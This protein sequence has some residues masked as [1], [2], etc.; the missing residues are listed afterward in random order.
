VTSLEVDVDLRDETGLADELLPLVRRYAE[1]AIGAEG[2][3]GSYELAVTLVDDERIRELNH[4]HRDKNEVTDVLSFPLVDEDTAGFILPGGAATHLGDVVIALG[5]MRE[6]AAQY[7]HSVERE[8]AYLTV[9]GVLHLL[10]YDHEDDED[11][12]HMR[13]REEEILAE[14]PR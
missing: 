5:R 8:L 2:L 7:G 4:Q 13:A 6:Q 11:K 12:V 3:S 14:L 10:G 1:Q 9:H